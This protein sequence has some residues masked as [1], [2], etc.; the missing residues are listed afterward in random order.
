MF[1]KL[2]PDAKSV[3]PRRDDGHRSWSIV[4]RFTVWYISSALALIFVTSAFLYRSVVKSLDQEEDLFLADS[5]QDMRDILENNDA[6]T[7]FDL[8]REVTESGYVQVYTRILDAHGRV[9]VETPGMDKTLVPGAFP[10]SIPIDEDPDHHGINLTAST[11][12]F[13]R[14]LSAQAVTSN[15]ETRVIQVALNQAKKL[16]LLKKYRTR[17][18]YILAI[19]LGAC[20]LIGYSIARRCIRPIGQISHA[21]QRMQST[22]LHERIATT[23]LPTELLSLATVF[24]EMLGRLEDSFTRLS[25][26]SANIAHEL[27][28]PVHNLRSMAEVALGS[29]RSPDEYRDTLASCLEECVRLSRVIDSLLF[30]ARA[31]Q[32]QLSIYREP[33]RI[34]DELAVVRE[35]YEA[36]ASE[37]GVTL[38][39]GAPQDL[40]AHL[41][42]TLF[43]RA[44]GNLITNALAYTSGGGVVAVTA[45]KTLEGTRI[46]VSDTGCGIP[47]DQAAHVFDRFYRVQLSRT[48][49]PGGMGLGLAIVKSIVTLHRGSASISSQMGR[50]TQVSLLF[51]P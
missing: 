29:M 12:R 38:K 6:P 28:T 9:I 37:A 16:G 14:G 48:T 10:P 33:L 20:T 11:G 8:Q 35:F 23:G 31:D 7:R 39:V 36:A 24:N 22:T 19:A 45:A 3:R 1:S 32:A 42:R 18:W 25:Q 13:F 27:R 50:G 47:A 26:F 46:E 40:V 30:L 44:I 15:H 49:K 17:L 51:P 5:V 21:A 2:A 41:D 4:T 43:Q 34:A